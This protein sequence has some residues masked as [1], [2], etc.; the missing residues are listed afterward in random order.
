M[1]RIRLIAFLALPL[2]LLACSG[3]DDLRDADGTVI[4]P[5]VASVFELVPGDCLNPEPGVTGEIDDMPLVPCDQEHTQEVFALVTAEEED[6]PGA[7]EVAIIADRRCL[8]ALQ[9]ELGLSLADGV[10][11]SYLLPTFDG[12]NT[13]GDRQIVCVLVF[14]NQESMTGSV[15]AGTADLAPAAP[16]EPVIPDSGDGDGDTADEPTDGAPDETP[17]GG[18]A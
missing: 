1:R 18:E 3:D 15:V 12:W 8:D 14:P 5:G 2:T 17:A 16:A 13:Q 4:N 6:Y 7:S 10:F 11:F 9:S